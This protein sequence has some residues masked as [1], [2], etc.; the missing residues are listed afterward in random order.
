MSKKQKDAARPLDVITTELSAVLQ[1]ETVCIIKSGI[2][3]IEAKAQVKHGQWLPYLSENFDLGERTAQRYM[4]AAEW[5]WTASNTTPVSDLKLSPTVLYG[6]ATGDY[7]PETAALIVEAAKSKWVNESRAIAIV[8]QAMRDSLQIEESED[9]EVGTTDENWLAREQAIE[10]EQRAR[11][12]A[13]EQEQRLKEEAEAILDNP[14]AD[15]L[16]PPE[17]VPLETDRYLHEKLA[18]LIIELKK[19]A[20][21]STDRFIASG[22]EPSDLETVSD[23]LKQ[24]ATKIVSRRAA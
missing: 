6:L 8:E 22:I 24:I 20:T 4:A 5:Y 16:P 2:L 3:L 7:E 14:P 12:R 21:K 15:L 11:E 19:L 1:S 10:Q 18:A 23:F 13:I 9:G 17:P